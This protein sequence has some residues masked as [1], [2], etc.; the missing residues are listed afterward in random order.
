MLLSSKRVLSTKCGVVMNEINTD[1]PS[2]LIKKEFV[3]LK[4][5]CSN[6]KSVSNY[7]LRGY[8]LIGVKSGDVIEKVPTIELVATLWNKRASET[9]FHVIGGTDVPN[10]QLRTGESESFSFRAMFGKSLRV[11]LV[12]INYFV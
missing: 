4:V 6:G 1:N 11:C 5:I 2:N 7:S 8:K 10:I 9:G 12:A 3:E